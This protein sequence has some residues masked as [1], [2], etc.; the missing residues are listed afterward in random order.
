[1]AEK[2][3]K[4]LS[5]EIN[6]GGVKH[7]DI[8]LFT[9][10]LSVALKSGL[11]MIEALD[12]LS[13]EASGKMKKVLIS[14]M[15]V[16]QSGRPLNEALAQY[17][18]YFTTVYVSL[19]KTGE[20]SGT[21]EENLEHLAEQLRKQH[22]MRQKVKSAMMYPM[23]IL[24]ATVGLGLS[25]ATFVLPKIVPLFSTLDVELPA[26]TRLLIWIADLFTNYGFWIFVA[27][28]AGFMFTGWLIKRKFMY[29][30]VHK[31]YIKMPVIG[32]IVV[33]INLESFT[34]TFGTLLS[35]GVPLD[36]SLNITVEATENYIY[37]KAIATF[38]G[39]V[40]KGNSLG[41]ALGFYPK[42]FPTITSRMIGM[43]EQTGNLDESLAYLSEYYEGEVDSA[44][45]NLS[46]VLEPLLLIGIGVMVGFVAISI[47]GPIYKITGN[48]RG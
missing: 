8:M 4:G 36:D 18:K 38:I 45:K 17:P 2:K 42:L 34:R 5:M 35:S 12:M 27:T 14:I 41:D 43:G 19:V 23:M 48:L 7:G 13:E 37:K 25:V 6:I 22:E 20:V 11:T 3:K 40:Q 10:H 39:E 33:A 1:M 46:T 30:L 26:S 47:L 16:I 21:V 28:V 32:P 44:V 31:L 15:Q 24:F 29:P 9:K